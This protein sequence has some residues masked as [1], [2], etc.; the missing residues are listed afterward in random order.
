MRTIDD[1]LLY[2]TSL[3]AELIEAPTP[4]YKRKPPY[5]G[6]IGPKGFTEEEFFELLEDTIE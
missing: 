4:N 5:P 6:V 2:A 1:L 3:P